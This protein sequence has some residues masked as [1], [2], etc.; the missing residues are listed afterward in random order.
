MA[1]RQTN[2]PISR[3]SSPLNKHD[4]W[5]SKIDAAK[6]AY[7]KKHGDESGFYEAHADLFKKQ[8]EARKAH[9]A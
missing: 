3:K 2:N 6:A 4:E 5:Q 9:E 8:E 1:Y 7:I